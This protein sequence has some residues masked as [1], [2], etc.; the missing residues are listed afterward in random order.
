VSFCVSSYLKTNIFFLV[1]TNFLDPDEWD[2]ILD[3]GNDHKI[4]NQKVGNEELKTDSA[5]RGACSINNSERLNHS[6]KQIVPFKP[7]EASSLDFK[8]GRAPSDSTIKGVKTVVSRTRSKYPCQ[9]PDCNK[10]FKYKYQFEYV[11]AI[12]LVG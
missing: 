2:M 7:S 12:L 11:A 1:E 5:N 6:K 4:R 8:E 10:I 3:T 9:L